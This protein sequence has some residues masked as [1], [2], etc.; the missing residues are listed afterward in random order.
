MPDQKHTDNADW[1]GDRRKFNNME[2]LHHEITDKVIGIFFQVY[3][4]LGFG[5]LERV[6]QNAMYLELKA[7]GFQ[8]ETEKK[9]KVHYK[10]LTDFPLVMFR[11]LYNIG[12]KHTVYLCTLHCTNA[13]LCI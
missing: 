9:I 12:W 7:Q 13:Y 10:I 1:G 8:C 5:F 6:Y 11:C 2:L 3:N 4:E